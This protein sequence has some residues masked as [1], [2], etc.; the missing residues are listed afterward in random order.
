MRTKVTLVL[1][2][3]NVALFFFIFR[4]ERDWRTE[5][6]AL[7]V[8]RRVLG[9]EAAD[10]RQLRIAGDSA[11]K[12][13]SYVLERRPEGWYLTA[14]LE[15]PANEFAVDNM[16]KELQFLDHIASFSVAELEKSGQSL[17]DFGLDRPRLTV[18]FVSGGSAAMGIAP[19]TTTLR[20]GS[21]TQVDNRL[22]V[23]SPDGGRVHVVEH[24][25]AEVFTQ[26]IERLRAN[27]LMTI[28]VFEATSLALRNGGAGI[29]PVVIRHDG[30]R[31]AYETPFTSRADR[32]AVELAINGLDSLQVKSFVTGGAPAPEQAPSLQARI[33][34]D[35]RSET[36][37]LGEPAAP[38]PPGAPAADY[39]AQFKEGDHLR[40]SVFIVSIPNAPPKG[41]LDTLRDPL[42]RLRERRILDFDPAAVTAITLSAPNQPDLT[43]QRL[44]APAGGSDWEVIRRGQAG[45]GPQTLPAD[46][47]AVQGLL[48]RLEQ[49]S[50]ETFQSDAPQATDL[51]NWGFNAPERQ[52]TLAVPSAP[53]VLQIGL[54]SR[55]DG[56]A[57]AKL[58]GSSSVYTVDP[59]IL[60]NTPLSPGD[61][62]NRILIDLPTGSRVTA[63]ALTDLTEH[64]V[65]F[66]RALGDGETWEHALASEPE[67]RR[68][69]VSAL[70][71][72]FNPLRAKR[73]MPDSFGAGV[74]AGGEERPWRYRMEITVALPAGGGRE[75]TVVHELELTERI[76]GDEQF[77]GSAEPAIDAVFAVEQPL[78]DALWTL[79]YAGPPK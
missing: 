7:E 43:L 18:T 73:F 10:I 28:P 42:E 13:G 61:W 38:P 31:W 5:R 41:L 71:R 15:W 12:G 67:A 45:Q 55:R 9:A 52:I 44:E 33:E 63:L 75:Q 16:I 39:Y 78:L 57:Y 30:D 23:L 29:A 60:D 3:L 22:Y 25:L 17:A 21:P 4:F 68:E 70:L 50:A 32:D 35:N 53:E 36:L 48:E 76:T 8:R 20:I 54:A 49:L 74:F 47:E 66:Q 1:L 34:G 6:A 62:R 56:P 26:P 14:P 37:I 58:A 46:R 51:E 40:P 2:F 77:A 79:T 65:V 19:I 64:R 69:A 24:E 11:V 72:Q 27:T 59:A